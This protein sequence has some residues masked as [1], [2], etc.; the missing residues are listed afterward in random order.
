MCKWFK[1]RIDLRDPTVPLSM[2]PLLKWVGGKTQILGEVLSTFPRTIENYYEP[3]LGG[4]SVLLGLLSSDIEVKGKIY[5]SDVNPI[6]IN[7]YTVLKEKPNDLYANFNKLVTEY[8]NSEDKEAFYYQTRTTFN[9]MAKQGREH[10]ATFLFLNKTCFRGVYREGPS[11]FN[12]PFGHYKS[13]PNVDETHLTDISKAI[14]RVE[15]RC[16]DFASVFPRLQKGDFLY[17]DPPYVPQSTT[18]FVGYV[19]DGFSAETYRNLFTGLRATPA[20]FVMSNSD[21]AIVRDAFPEPFQ[22][23]KIVARRAI[24]SK[25]PSS[26]TMEVLI[27]N[28][29]IHLG[30]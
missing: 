25:D 2:K 7:F 18:S 17:V 14:Q 11:G 26:T 22:T 13:L 28:A 15:F 30:A 9:Q 12:V 10:A 8:S 4:G 27:T 3:F 29:A 16:H 21:V 24:H 19:A 1:K 23:K 6:L 20:T 5:A